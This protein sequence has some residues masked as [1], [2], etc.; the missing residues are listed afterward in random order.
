M[1]S[2]RKNGVSYEGS[3][4]LY[5]LLIDLF[6]HTSTSETRSVQEHYEHLKPVIDYIGNHFDQPITLQDLANCLSVTPHYICVLFQQTFSTRPF[7][8]INRF[9]IQKAKEY[10][11]QFP[12]WEIQTIARKVGFESPSYFIKVFKKNEGLTPN[13]FRKLHV[14]R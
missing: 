14:I 11:Q 2:I 9:R 13:D 3:Q 10:L 4:L 1:F 8:Y 12:T 7:E 6:Q 5:G